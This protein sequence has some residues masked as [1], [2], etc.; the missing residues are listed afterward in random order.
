M[1]SLTVQ[2]ILR[3][4]I[5]REVESQRLYQDLGTRVQSPAARYAFSLLVSQEEGHQHILERYLKGGLAEGSLDIK[6]VVDYHIAE[7]LQQP[8]VTPGMQLPDIFLVAARRE[9]N[10]FDFYTSL[11]DIHP[12]GEMKK[13]LNK[14]AAEE[15]GHKQKV[16]SLYA[17]VAFP[18]TDGG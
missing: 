13:L 15:L 1:Q 7:H 18:Q 6:H 16:E 4:G 11:A 14:L 5:A 12:E 10:S 9:R 3:Q 8:E 17:E 2:D